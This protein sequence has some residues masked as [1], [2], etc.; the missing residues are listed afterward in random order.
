L[1]PRRGAAGQ[2]PDAG[3]VERPTFYYDLASPECW[4]VAE[5]INGEL[6]V[7]PV[8]QPV[9]L[10]AVLAAAGEPSARAPAANGRR[11]AAIE[12]GAAA[13]GL[14]APR[15]PEP[16]PADTRLAMRAAAFAQASGRAVAFSLAAFRQAFAAGRNLGELDTVLLAAAACELHPRAVTKGL[17]TRSVLERLAAACREA[18]RAGVRSVPALRVGDRVEAGA[19]LAGR[20]PAEP[21]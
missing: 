11:R 9:H 16:F 7:V 20:F 8:W 3:P 14:P 21:R 12:A 4:L 15:W 2:P 6:P 18:A 1:E 10:P 13:A 5:R 19:A 17:E